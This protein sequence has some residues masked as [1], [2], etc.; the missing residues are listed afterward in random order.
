M[1]RAITRRRASRV[2]PL[3]VGADPRAVL[4]QEVEAT[5]RQAALEHD[6]V[7]VVGP[8]ADLG[9][10]REVRQHPAVL[11]AGLDLGIERPLVEGLADGLL[12]V[13]RA[14]RRSRR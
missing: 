4:A 7:V 1:S 13:A 14:R 5:D 10:L 6:P 3:A 8:A 9:V 2:E 12:Q 11:D